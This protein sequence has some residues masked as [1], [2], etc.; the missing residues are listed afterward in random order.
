M[1]R[2]GQGPGLPI[3]AENGDVVAALVAAIEEATGGIERKAAGIV[4][5]GPLLA[6]VGQI[7]V[8]ADPKDPDAVMQPVARVDKPSVGGNQDLGAEVA[9]GKSGGKGG[10][11]LPRAQ[12][13]GCGIV[14]EEHDGGAFLLDRIEP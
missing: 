10:D 12:P 11:R 14:V 4:A 6:E 5:A 3:D 2:E 7:S 13:S 9:A 8:L 1:A